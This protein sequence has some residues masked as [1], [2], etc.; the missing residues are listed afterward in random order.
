MDTKQL[1]ERDICTKFITPALEIRPRT[2][3]RPLVNVTSSRS[4]VAKVDELMALCD[5]LEAQL[6]AGDHTR[7][8]LLDALIPETLAEP[9]AQPA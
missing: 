2:I 8:R 1:S 4:C 5:Q 3:T 6:K 7:S 9:H